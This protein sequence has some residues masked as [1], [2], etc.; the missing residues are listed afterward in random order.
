[1]PLV[2]STCVL[3]PELAME[4]KY[5]SEWAR[6]KFSS[7]N[8]SREHRACTRVCTRVCMCR[9]CVSAVCNVR[10]RTHEGACT[11]MGSCWFEPRVS[12]CRHIS[13]RHPCRRR[14]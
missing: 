1:M 3:R 7:L 5:F 8:C 2:T 6:L 4:S 12:P 10:A 9:S 14:S 11:E 13:T